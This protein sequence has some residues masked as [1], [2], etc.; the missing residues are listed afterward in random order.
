[1]SA[2]VLAGLATVLLSGCAQWPVAAPTPAPAPPPVQAVVQPTPVPTPAPGPTAAPPQPAAPDHPAGNPAATLEN[3]LMLAQTRQPYDL[4][5]AQVLLEPLA[6]E[7]APAPWANLARLLQTRLADQRRLEEQA[8][9]Q[10]QQLREQQRR[11][12]QLASQLA[13]LKAI[14]RS[15]ATRPIPPPPAA[16][17]PTRTP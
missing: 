11:L 9:R 8:E 10:A 15:L 13:A 14:E 2:Y 6:R 17:P 1:M 3:A 16:S 4:A 7:G 5:R 12:D